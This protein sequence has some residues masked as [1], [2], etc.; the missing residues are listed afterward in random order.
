MSNVLG[1]LVKHPTDDKLEGSLNLLRYQGPVVT[2]IVESDNP[3]APKY[4]L[5]AVT[6]SG[7]LIQIGSISERITKSSNKPYLA[8]KIDYVEI[9]DK[10]I[11]GNL[12]ATKKDANKLLLLPNS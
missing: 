5:H 1:T 10:P 4:E 3:D 9:T 12:A 11:Y 8:F 7:S 2:T 6:G